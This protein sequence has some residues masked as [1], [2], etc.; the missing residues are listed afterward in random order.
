MTLQPFSIAVPRATLD[1]LAARLAATRFPDQIAG[2]GWD[3]G[4]D[5]SYVR[6]LVEHWRAAFDWRAQEKRLNGF[7]QFTAPVGGS[8]IHFVH[9][10][11]RLP[12]AIP[13]LLLHGWPS[14]FAQMLKLAPLLVGGG[15]PAF[16]V[17]APSLIGYGFSSIPREPGMSVA[18]MAPLLD[19]LMREVLGYERYGIR[20]GDLGAGIARQIA[21]GRPEAVIGL[22]SGG[23]N[24]WIGQVPGDLSPAEKAFVANA[25]AWNRDE[26]AYAMLHATRPQTLAHALNDSP[27]GL[28]AWIIEKLRRWSDCD[29]NIEA[30]FS[31]DDLLTNVMIYWITGTIGSSMRLY[32]ETMRDQGSWNQPSVPVAMLMSPKDMFPTPREWAERSGR[33]ARWTEIDRGGHFLE[34]EEPELVATDL[35]AFFGGL[36]PGRGR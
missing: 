17:V 18:A 3:Y 12:D 21:L 8:V 31:R 23:T 5:T 29:G 20:A 16:H 22:H 34:L 9:L 24:P 1:D 15:A 19:R 33:I 11:S 32:Y 26:M 30:R 13:L 25:E 14:T 6:G 7:P 10:R 4:T 28:A 2:S 36:E 35:R 27:A